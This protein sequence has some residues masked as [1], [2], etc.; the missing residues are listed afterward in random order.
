MNKEEIIDLLKKKEAEYIEASKENHSNNTEVL[1]NYNHGVAVGLRMAIS[2]VGMLDKSNNTTTHINF[3]FK[4]FSDF[5]D[6]KLREDFSYIPLEDLSKLA[7]LVY[8]HFK[9]DISIYFCDEEDYLSKKFRD[10]SRN[11]ISIIIDLIYDYV[12]NEI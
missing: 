7:K 5:I 3:D 1:S 9:R 10:I 2:T 11:D 6:E 12:V 4:K 8:I